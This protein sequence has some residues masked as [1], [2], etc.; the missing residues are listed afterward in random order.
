MLI[1]LIDPNVNFFHTADMAQRTVIEE[2]RK[3]I[4]TFVSQQEKV[5]IHTLAK[6]TNATE[7]TIRRDLAFLEQEN[8][9]TRTHGGAKRTENQ[10]LVW[11]IT[12]VTE[13]LQK[14][15][16]QKTRIAQFAA[17][18][19]DD[20]DSIM[21]D[22][23]STTQLMAYNL[24]EKRDLL[25]VTNSPDIAKILLDTDD[26]KVVQLG[27]EMQRNTFTVSGPEAEEHLAH[28]FVDKSIIGV[29]GADLDHGCYAA[30]PSE[31]SLKRLMLR[32][33]RERIVLM[34]SSKFGRKAFS[35]AFPFNM[36]DILVT[37]TEAPSDLIIK[38]KE[39]NVKVYTV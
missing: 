12:S 32:Q 4:A 7:Y 35:L 17:S 39:M 10:K 15:R 23:G 29:S 22:G 18:L 34:D 19:V 13:R 16:E 6:L 5:D 14:N 36:V 24:K 8:L 11:Q 2:R 20:N 25:A 9:I 37:D 30:I 38:L 31:A 33:S 27:G 28:F 3:K 21:I 26:A 1:F